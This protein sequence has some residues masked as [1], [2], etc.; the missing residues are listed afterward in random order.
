MYVRVFDTAPNYYYTDYIRVTSNHNRVPQALVYGH[1]AVIVVVDW[2]AVV[3]VDG[4]YA[5]VK[6]NR[7]TDVMG[8][9][10]WTRY[11]VTAKLTTSGGENKTIKY[12][13]LHGSYAAPCSSS[14]RTLHAY[15]LGVIEN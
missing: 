5:W 1:R 2:G 4:G 8:L 7:T 14:G 13:R 3:A 12:L 10:R 9:G 6:R 15:L 11:Y